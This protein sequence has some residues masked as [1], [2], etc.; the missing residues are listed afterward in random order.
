MS[1]TNNVVIVGAARTAIGSFGGML[2][3]FS[4]CGL[5]ATIVR[6]A[7][8]RRSATSKTLAGDWGCPG[9]KRENQSASVSC[10]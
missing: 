2:K 3:D 7:S 1:T 10:Y 8:N 5:G 4:A 9:A 6:E